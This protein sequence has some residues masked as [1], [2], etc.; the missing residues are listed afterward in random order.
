MNK[1]AHLSEP[2][3]QLDFHNQ[4]SLTPNQIKQRLNEFIQESHQKGIKK[5][6]I[7]TGKGLHSENTAVVRPLVQN[8]LSSHPLVKSTLTARRDRG[9]EGAFEV[10]LNP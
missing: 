6:L 10:L 8:L 5:L 2:E 9:G 7:I 1:Y 4:G 3:A